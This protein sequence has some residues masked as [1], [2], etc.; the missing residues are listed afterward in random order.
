MYEKYFRTQFCS[1][2][3]QLSFIGIR[4]HS[5][6]GLFEHG[7]T[8][9]VYYVTTNCCVV[10]IIIKMSDF[11]SIGPLPT[12]IMSQRIAVSY[13]GNVATLCI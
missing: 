5:D 9:D 7:T 10:S 13:L 12:C 4:I 11:L 2:I 1:I 6:P 3:S 8:S